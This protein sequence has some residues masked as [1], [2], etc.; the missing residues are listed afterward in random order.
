MRRLKKQY[1]VLVFL[2]SLKFAVWLK[3]FSKNENKYVKENHWII[4]KLAITERCFDNCAWFNLL[5]EEADE[6]IEK[7]IKSYPIDK[8]ADRIYFPSSFIQ[9]L[10]W[11]QVRVAN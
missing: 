3:N 6:F 8:Y 11:R 9:Y 4:A 2:I 7:R 10:T 5:L 1:T